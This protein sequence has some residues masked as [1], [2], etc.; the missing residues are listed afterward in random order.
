[1]Y[2]RR[3]EDNYLHLELYWL[4][5]QITSFKLQITVEIIC[6]VEDVYSVFVSRIDRI[7]H[8]M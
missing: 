8:G 1:M 7:S 3:T 2:Y 6:K 5:P 4:C